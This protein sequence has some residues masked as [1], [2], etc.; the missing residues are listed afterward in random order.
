M[1]IRLLFLTGTWLLAVGAGFAILQNYAVPPGYPGMPRVWLA[2]AKSSKARFRTTA[3]LIMAV[4]PRWSLFQGQHCFVSTGHDA[5]PRI[6][7]GSRALLQAKRICAGVGT[8]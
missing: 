1:S 5:Q 8:N 2:N 7:H 3:T 6:G 4:H